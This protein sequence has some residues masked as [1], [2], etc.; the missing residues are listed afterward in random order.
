M[1][2]LNTEKQKIIAQTVLQRSGSSVDIAKAVLF[3]VRD[4]DYISGQVLN[5]DGGRMLS[6]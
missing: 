4:A 1:H 3:F 5:I 6:L 2:Y